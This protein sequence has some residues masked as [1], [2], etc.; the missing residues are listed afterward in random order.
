MVSQKY[1]GSCIGAALAKWLTKNTVASQ[2][3]VLEEKME[4]G[5]L[6][7]LL[8]FTSSYG[9]KE[10]TRREDEQEDR[11]WF[12]SRSRPSASPS[13]YRFRF[14]LSGNIVCALCFP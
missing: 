9:Q 8:A 7:M 6:E 1:R 4:D 12:L 13:L 10:N 3:M 11:A 2:K 5:A 14:N